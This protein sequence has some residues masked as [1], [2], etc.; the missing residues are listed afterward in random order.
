EA[1]AVGVAQALAPDLDLARDPRWG[2]TEETYGEDP[3]LVS[4]MGVAYVKGLQGE[5]PSIDG[6]HLIATAKHYAA[7]GS[8]E[9]G[10][11]L[12][13]VAGGTRE[14][15][16]A[17]LPPFKAVVT[18]AGVLCVI[19]AYSEYDGIP[20]SAS[21][22]LLTR[23]L[24][25]E[26]GFRGYV[27]SDYGAITM[28]HTLHKTA[29]TRAEAA[30]QALEAGMDLEAPN[31]ECFGDRLLGLVRRGEVSVDLIDRSVARILRLKFLAGLFE[32][33][34]ASVDEAVKLVN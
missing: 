28:L 25:E 29:H 10:V 21:K 18:E 4:R 13:P 8:P 32:N 1:R 5:G 22:L 3:Y 7:H 34:Y 14:L 12:A 26:W 2:R 11:N 17:Y 9:A 6:Q 24:R 33:P 15:R 16:T 27:F 31:E 19:P 23:V 30:R 20:A